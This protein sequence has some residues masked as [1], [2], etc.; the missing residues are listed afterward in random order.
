MCVPTNLCT[1]DCFKHLNS[2]ATS[3]RLVAI[4]DE[5]VAPTQCQCI[6]ISMELSPVLING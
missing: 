2:H 3:K 4:T 6:I 1:C 5:V